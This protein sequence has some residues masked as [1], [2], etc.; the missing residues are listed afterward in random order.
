MTIGIDARLYSPKYTGIGR[1]VAEFIKHAAELDSSNSFIVYLNEPE[2]SQF[3]VPNERWTKKLLNIPH[4]SLAEQTRYLSFLNQESVDMMYFPHFNL[5]VLYKKPYVVTIHDL[6]LHY[7]PYKEYHPKWS[8]KKQLQ[9]WAYRFIMK[10]A[11]ANSQHVIAVSENTKQDIMREYHTD[12]EKISVIYEG[13][14]D[15]FAPTP[16]SGLLTPYLLYTGVWRSHKNLLNLIKAFKKI[17][18]QHDIDLVVTGK[19]DPAYPEI[20]QLIE[21]LGLQEHIRLPGFVSDEELIRLISEA[22]VYVFPSLYEG[23]GLPPL[24]AMQLGVPVA[25]SNT[26]SLPEVCA[27]AALYFDPKNPEDMAIQISRFLSD[28]QLKQE[29]IYK[30]LQNVKRFSWRA[31]TSQV[32][33]K[34]IKIG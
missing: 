13:V 32:I 16:D 30:G 11:I 33:D 19:K 17:R 27:E 31:M 24:E 25:C 26:S 22:E 5:P 29:Y 9:I 3:S 21:E 23:F 15:H 4:Y 10:R 12:P 8:L 2:F 1:Y 20:P 7:Y 28:P 34:I 14:P 6:T 18:E